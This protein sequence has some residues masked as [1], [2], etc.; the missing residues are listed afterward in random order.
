MTPWPFH[1]YVPQIDWRTK[2]FGRPEILPLPK[3]SL[4]APK[5]EPTTDRI[6]RSNSKV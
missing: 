1:N 3:R 6:K 4:P 5:A 2:T